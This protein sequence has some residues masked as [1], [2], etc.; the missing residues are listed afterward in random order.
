[1]QSWLFLGG[2]A[3]LTEIRVSVQVASYTNVFF[4]VSYMMYTGIE[5]PMYVNEVSYTQLAVVHTTSVP[6]P[7]T[8][9][10]LANVVGVV[11]G[12]V[13]GFAALV[14]A[15]LWFIKMRR[16]HSTSEY[17]LS[18]DSGYRLDVRA[19]NRRLQTDGEMPFAGIP[20]MIDIVND[21]PQVAF[22]P[23]ESNR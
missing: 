21:L 8:G 7:N 17:G 18:E 10:S 20:P 4:T 2:A 1:M 16:S 3:T 13:G 23:A 15:V 12:S 14:G 22:R 5:F 6:E 9:L 11:A 19:T